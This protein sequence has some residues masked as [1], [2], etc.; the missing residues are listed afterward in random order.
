MDFGRNDFQVGELLLEPV[1]ASC[2]PWESEA[3]ADL[4]T[5]TAGYDP[6][7]RASAWE[8]RTYMQSILLRDTD[9]M[10]MAHALEVRVPLI[11][12]RLV[13]FMFSLNGDCKVDPR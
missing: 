11:D 8:L 9:Q 13:E 4:T 2:P 10:S 3:L 6:V 1:L 5:E 7:N 12:H